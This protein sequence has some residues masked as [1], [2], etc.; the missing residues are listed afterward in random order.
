MRSLKHYA[1]KL[2]III[3]GQ[4]QPVLLPVLRSAHDTVSRIHNPDR[5]CCRT[6]RKTDLRR[7][8]HRY[9]CADPG[10]KPCQA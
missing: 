10:W 3:S 1:V 6:L 9:R 7:A 8:R 5:S 2:Q 4:L